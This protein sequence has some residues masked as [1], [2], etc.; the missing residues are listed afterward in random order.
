M[1]VEA[2]RE[3]YENYHVPLA[4]RHAGEL[5]RLRYVRSYLEPPP[6]RRIY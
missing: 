4:M 2:F 5:K 6:S 1:A 3:Y